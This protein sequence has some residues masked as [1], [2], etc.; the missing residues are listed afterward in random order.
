LVGRANRYIEETA[1]FKIAKDPAQAERL[2]RILYS[3]VETC[4]VLAVL[5]QPYLPSTA[6]R[7]YAQLGLTAEPTSFADAQWGQLKQG[8]AISE[9]KPLFPRKDQP[10]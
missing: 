9:V 8:A 6:R 3:L 4:R 5:L 1:P 10:T 2:D 7:I